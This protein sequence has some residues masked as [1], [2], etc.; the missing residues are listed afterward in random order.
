MEFSIKQGSPEKLKSACVVV[1]VFEDGKLS[2]AAHAIDTASKNALSHLVA[3]GDLSGKAAST[4]LLHKLEGV[5]A[6]RVLL[7]GLGKAEK[8]NSKV[9]SD[10]LRAVFAAL[11]DTPIKNV[12]LF[13]LDEQA[14]KDAEWLIKQKYLRLRN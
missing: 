12:A 3:R 8:L 6:E 9:S 7:V 10:I 2:A 11:N 13:I 5:A 4:L 1:G 14:G